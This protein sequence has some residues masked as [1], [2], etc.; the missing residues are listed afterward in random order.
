MRIP[1]IPGRILESPHEFSLAETSISV[2]T[3]G[4]LEAAGIFTVEEL[5]AATEAELLCCK[6]FG[7]KGLKE[8]HRALKSLG[9]K[10]RPLVAA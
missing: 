4:I 2:R 5:L 9:I 10:E 1:T 6:N 3:C 7:E 8:V